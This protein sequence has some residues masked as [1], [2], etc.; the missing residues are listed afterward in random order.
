M[1]E[2]DAETFDAILR[3]NLHT[4]ARVGLDGDEIAAILLDHRDGV[5]WKGLEEHTGYQTYTQ[6]RDCDCHCTDSS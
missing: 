3:E 6:H 2:Y 1:G 5:L 4:A